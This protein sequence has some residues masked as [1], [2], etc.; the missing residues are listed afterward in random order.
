MTTHS[1]WRKKD[2]LLV[3]TKL[4]NVAI[5]EKSQRIL[6]GESPSVFYRPCLKTQAI[7]PVWG[8]AHV[9]LFSRSK[10]RSRH[11]YFLWTF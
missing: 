3:Y 9:N 7:G 6:S 5:L 10:N 1:V 11:I 4:K 8:S 2:Q